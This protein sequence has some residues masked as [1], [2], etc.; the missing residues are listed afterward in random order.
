MQKKNRRDFL[1]TCTAAGACAPLASWGAN[2]TEETK[3][4]GMSI[5]RY[6]NPSEDPEEEAKEADQ[7]T[8]GAIESLGGMARF[9]SKGEVVWIKPNICFDRTPEQA[10]N[11]NPYVVGTIVR[12]CRE[13]GAKEVIV[14][15]HPVGDLTR[16]YERSKIGPEAEKAGARVF[17]MKDE[18]FKTTPI[19]GKAIK[20]CDIYPEVLEVD[21]LIAIATVKHHS[22]C[23]ASLGMKGLMGLISGPRYLFH[24]DIDN[25]IPDLAAFLNPQLVVL[26]AI[27]VLKRDG[28]F[29]G[30]LDD[31]ERKDT[32][33]VST[34]QVAADAF[35]A[36]CFGLKPEEV[37]YIKEAD[38]RGMGTMDYK[39]LSP[40]ELVI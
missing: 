1:L 37:G 20:E 24:S 15:N 10:V 28:P 19:G 39:S 17:I 38:A 33:A 14:S 27:R 7:L 31:V 16:A 8:R 36:V 13:A 5:A 40:V 2:Q 3:H 6:K 32:V 34:D 21:K 12:L 18:D 22:L 26:D 35:G 25:S 30:S 4:P 29:G 23:K 9:V 11:S